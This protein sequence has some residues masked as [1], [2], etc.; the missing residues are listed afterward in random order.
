MRFQKGRLY[1]K[2]K[3]EL[4]RPVVTAH[5]PAPLIVMIYLMR[6]EW[7]NRIT[8]RIM[9]FPKTLNVWE[10]GDMFLYCWRTLTNVDE[11]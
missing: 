11:R 10:C 5:H 4:F 3:N 2:K 7:M 6:H 9:R 1:V 8:A